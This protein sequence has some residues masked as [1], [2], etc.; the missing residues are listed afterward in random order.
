MSDIEKHDEEHEDDSIPFFPDHAM[1]EIY[2]A[3][4]VL[5]VLLVVGI[6]GQFNPIGLEE[7][8]DPMN[9]PEHATPEWYFLFLYQFLKYV[10]KTLGVMAPIVGL[11]L[12]FLVPF[13]DRRRENEEQGKRRRIIGVAVFLVIVGVLTILGVT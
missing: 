12:L 2:V 11:I 5:L 3:L 1:T 8:A 6:L 4:V 13:L 9:T 10:P 7:P